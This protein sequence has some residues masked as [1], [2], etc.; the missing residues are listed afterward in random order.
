LFYM[1]EFH[2]LTVKPPYRARCEVC[3]GC[4][5]VLF[6]PGAEETEVRCGACCGD[7]IVEVHPSGDGRWRYVLDDVMIGLE[8]PPW[9]RPPHRDL[10]YGEK[11]EAAV[12]FWRSAA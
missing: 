8:P 5:Y 1:R 6:V 7:G 9:E 10:M 3:K 12:D 11:V 2:T 4:G